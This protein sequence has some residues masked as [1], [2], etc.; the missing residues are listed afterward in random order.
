[1]LIS[2][3]EGTS[4]RYVK[5]ICQEGVVCYILG[6]GTQVGVKCYNT[7]RC[8]VLDIGRWDTSGC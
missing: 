7:R 8:C 1:M 4:R 2:V 6:V 5:R 3:K